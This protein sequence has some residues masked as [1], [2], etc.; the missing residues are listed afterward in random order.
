[1]TENERKILEE[2]AL[3]EKVLTAAQTVEDYCHSRKKMCWLCV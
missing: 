2:R 1:M 3:E